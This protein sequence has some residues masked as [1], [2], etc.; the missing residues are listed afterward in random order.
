MSELFVHYSKDNSNEADIFVISDGVWE[1]IATLH[2]RE[3]GDLQGT[4]DVPWR[5]AKH[6]DPT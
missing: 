4:V 3:D 1:K 2:I 6:K 5:I